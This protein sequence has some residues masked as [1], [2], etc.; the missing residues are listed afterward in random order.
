MTQLT[1]RNQY[2]TAP[3]IKA[4]FQGTFYRVISSSRI[5]TRLHSANLPAQ[6]VCK[7]LVYYLDTVLCVT[8]GHVTIGN[9]F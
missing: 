3:V 4:H 9:G 5:R 8:T 6:R 7:S 1:C 2:A